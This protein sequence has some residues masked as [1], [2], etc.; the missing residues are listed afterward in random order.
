MLAVVLKF[1]RAP[2]DAARWG[3]GADNRFHE[4][5]GQFSDI[6]NHPMGGSHTHH[7]E[8]HL[9]CTIRMVHTKWVEAIADRVQVS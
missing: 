5:M 7:I 3:A 2:L 9:L 8:K 4:N 6:A 1:W